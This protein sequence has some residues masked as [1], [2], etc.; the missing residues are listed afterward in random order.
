MI[1]A[2]RRPTLFGVPEA[3]LDALA[4]ASVLLAMGVLPYD[5]ALSVLSNPAPWTIVAMF[6]IMMLMMKIIT[7][8]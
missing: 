2:T 8:T 3:R 6:I 7:T 4:G 1:P 5:H